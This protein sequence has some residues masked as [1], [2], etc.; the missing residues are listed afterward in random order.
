MRINKYFIIVSLLYSS[1]ALSE[2]KMLACEIKAGFDIHIIFT[3]ETNNAE[4]VLSQSS[5]KGKSLISEHHYRFEFPKTSTRQET[6]I[7]VN[8]YN[9]KLEWEIGEPPFNNFNIGNIT[10]SG[11][12]KLSKAQKAL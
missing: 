5:V 6:H 10:S 7:V 8:R 12:C 3:P 2:E 1:N 11:T 9:G 4:L